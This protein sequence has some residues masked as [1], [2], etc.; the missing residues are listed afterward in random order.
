MAQ[1]QGNVYKPRYTLAY[2]AKSKVWPYK[3]SYLRRFYALRARRV[4]RGGLFRR[5]VLV[6]T[7][8]KWTIARRFIR[9]FRRRAG[10]TPAAGIGG[11][12]AYGRPFKRRYRHSFYIKQQLRFFHG[13]RKESTFRYLFQ[14]YQKAVA[15]RTN[16]FFSALESR[17]DRFFF[18]R[19]FLPTIYACHQFIHHHG[20]QVNGVQE[21][22]P[23]A[24]VQVGDIISIPAKSWKPFYWDLFCRV[25]YR[26]WGL[27]IFRRRQYTQLKKKLFNLQSRRR[28]TFFRLLNVKYPLITSIVKFKKAFFYKRVNKDYT[29]PSS[30]KTKCNR[31]AFDSAGFSFVGKYFKGSHRLSS[32]NRIRPKPQVPAYPTQRQALFNELSSNKLIS[33]D[34]QV[35]YNPIFRR[36][37]TSRTFTT[38]DKG[39]KN[40]SSLTN[41]RGS[42][43]GFYTYRNRMLANV[44]GNSNGRQSSLHF[45]KLHT[46]Q[47][48]VYALRLQKSLLPSV[49]RIRK[50]LKATAR[51]K[52]LDNKSRK[53]TGVYYRA[54]LRSVF[55]RFRKKR[56]KKIIRRRKV[57]RLKT[58]HFYIPSYI[59]RDFRTLRAIKIQSPS[60]TDIHHSFR[61]SLAKV[62]SFYSARGY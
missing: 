52:N 61:G 50:A 11:K 12:T 37:S 44:S 40:I 16:S 39:V 29:I 31:K 36:L 35:R 30:L 9:P 45:K 7:T 25:Y 59:Q 60:L 14:H 46:L 55:R 17:L 20:L 19:R 5:C 8:R 49:I 42:L 24:L 48:F 38:K 57:V 56:S 33:G 28:R 32:V 1:A 6:A 47:K 2:L 41:T 27:Y 23:R 26:R 10:S 43:K 62:H 3:D 4:Q 18:R 51:G 15:N 21:R 34:K 53:H 54:Y 58:V 13:K 22:S